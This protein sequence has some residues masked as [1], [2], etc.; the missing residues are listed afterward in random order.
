MN[1][2]IKETIV[3]TRRLGKETTQMLLE[4]DIIVSDAKPDMAVILKTDARACID[5]TEVSTDRVSFTGKL[6]LK[7]LYLAKGSDKP[8]HSMSAVM[9]IDDFIKM[10]GVDKEMWVE[11][12]ATVSNMDYRMVNDRKVNYRAAIDIRISAEAKVNHEVVTGIADLPESQVKKTRLSVN[13]TIECKEERFTVKNDLP[14]PPG[15]P[16]IRG[17]LQSD[18]IMTNKEIKVMGGRVGVTGEITISTLYMGDDDGIVEF[19]EHEL[20]WSGQIDAVGARDGMLGDLTLN[21]SDFN[22]TVGRDDDGED[23][24]ICAEA[25]VTASVRVT[26]QGEA[27]ILEDAYY[28]NKNLIFNR[29]NVRF[30]RLVCRNKNQCP[31]KEVVQLDPECPD[32]LQIFQVTGDLV[33]DNVRLYEDRIVVEGIISSNILYIANKDDSPLYN[34]KAFLPFKQTIEAKGAMPQMEISIDHTIDHIGFNML[35]DRE[36]E[37][38]CLVSFNARV[39]ENRETG[40]I[41]DILFEDMDRA[42]LDKTASVTVYCIQPG[43]SL[44][45]I[46]KKYN[47]SPEDLIEINELSGA[48]DIYPGLKLLVLKKVMV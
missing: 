35:S 25:V 41:T 9:P 11:A 5:R 22:V 44:W 37:V 32:M 34:Y 18:A 27:V 8:I 26:S 3:L 29:E 20:P 28:I 4:G 2:L 39:V 16:N 1:E 30:P 19:V 40:V 24:V 47:T 14:L 31:I 12:T 38:R 7:V 42:F 48:E 43:D 36:V 33:L 6:H 13:R 17:I 46:A 23:R 21:I 45:D 10:D 15:K